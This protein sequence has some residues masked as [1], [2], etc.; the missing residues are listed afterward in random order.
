[1]TVGDKPVFPVTLMFDLQIWIVNF[2][3][4]G[5]IYTEFETA[6]LKTAT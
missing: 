4:Q 2:G 1:M 3:V 6:G 5:N